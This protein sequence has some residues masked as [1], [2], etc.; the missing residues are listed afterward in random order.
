MEHLAE[1]V[2]IFADYLQVTTM[3]SDN[4]T[5]APTA[6]GNDNV[7]GGN[8]NVTGAPNARGS[9]KRNRMTCCS[10]LYKFGGQGLHDAVQTERALRVVSLILSYVMLC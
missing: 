4:A 6:G 10:N 3:A 2:C 8:D 1:L 5:G 9:D 7:A